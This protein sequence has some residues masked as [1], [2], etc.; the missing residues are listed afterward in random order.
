ML[1]GR[2]FVPNS[3]FVICSSLISNSRLGTRVHDVLVFIISII[4][5]QELKGDVGQ[6]LRSKATI[7]LMDV[8]QKRSIASL[9]G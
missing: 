8:Q 1:D 6:L 2:R 9:D 4:V 3:L 7:M 5:F